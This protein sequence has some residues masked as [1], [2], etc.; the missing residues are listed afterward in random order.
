[1]ARFEASY[2]GAVAQVLAPAKLESY[3]PLVGR[4]RVLDVGCGPGLDTCE[5]S[6]LLGPEAL[7]IGIDVDHSHVVAA[8]QRAEDLGL[9]NVRHQAGTAER[10]PFDDHSFDGVRVDRLLQHLD[11]PADALREMKR[12]L[13][14]GGCLVICDTDWGS[15]SF[16]HPNSELERKMV[17]AQNQ[18]MQRN[19]YVG[20]QLWRLAHEIDLQEVEVR[21]LSICLLDREVARRVVRLDTL[22]EAVVQEGLLSS[23]ELIAWQTGFEGRPY[24][25]SATMNVVSG[26]AR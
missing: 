10:L 16:D 19:G 2:L 25:V 6:R 5:L 21:S 7:I 4:R 17:R 3:R 15:L 9:T 14:P 22:E 8:N 13:A 12:V 11:E 18:L 24:F 26:V 23:S 1:M 20:R